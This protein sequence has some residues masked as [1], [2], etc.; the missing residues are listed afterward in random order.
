[1]EKYIKT[2]K[3]WPPLKSNSKE[4]G[5]VKQEVYILYFFSF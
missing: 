1:M 5:S 2:T 3:K 4:G